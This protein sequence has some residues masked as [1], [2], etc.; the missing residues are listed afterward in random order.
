MLQLVDVAHHRKFGARA[1]FV[2]WSKVAKVRLG[3]QGVR[4]LGLRV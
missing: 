4:V 3:L 2:M 1:L